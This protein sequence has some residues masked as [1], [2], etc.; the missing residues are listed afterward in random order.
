M[1]EYSESH[2]VHRL[3]LLQAKSNIGTSARYCKFWI[4]QEPT[5]PKKLKMAAVYE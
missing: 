3:H 5:S 2:S 1:C 4:E